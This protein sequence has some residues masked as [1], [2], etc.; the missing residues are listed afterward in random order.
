[1]PIKAKKDKKGNFFQFG[2]TGKKYYYRM[3]DIRSRELAYDKA[4]RQGQA[5]SISK[6]RR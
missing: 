1:M 2:K 3:N 6:R 5:I 4:L